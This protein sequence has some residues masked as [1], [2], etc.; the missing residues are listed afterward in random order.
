MEI[1]DSL[2]NQFKLYNYIAKLNDNILQYLNNN[3]INANYYCFYS[4]IINNKHYIITSQTTKRKLNG[5]RLITIC[6]AEKDNNIFEHSGYLDIIFENIHIKITPIVDNIDDISNKL[7]ILITHFDNMLV[8][9][10]A[11]DFK[12]KYDK[13]ILETNI[14]KVDNVMDLNNLN[15][16]ENLKTLTFC[17]YYNQEVAVNVLPNSLLTLIF[18]ARYNQAIGVNMLPNSLQTLTF[19]TYYNQVIGVNAL[20]NSLQ[21]LTF[22]YYYNQTIG[23]NV[24]PNSLHT[25]TFGDRY[26]QAIGVNVLPNSLQTLTF[27]HFYNQTICVNVLPNS[28][29]TLTF[30]CRYNRTIDENVF[31]KSLQAIYLN[32]HNIY[33]KTSL[34]CTIP[35][36]FQNKV[37]CINVM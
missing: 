3:N 27:G 25:L 14:T 37:N 21:T 34:T 6:D 32:F 24:L 8:D 2:N 22:G 1:H 13:N 18:G 11:V 19:G 4:K 33:M 9:N 28:L 15:I 10:N 26:N 5:Y 35:E 20:P 31:P 17:W 16:F 12:Y 7:G 36:K 29:Q 30:S 23:V